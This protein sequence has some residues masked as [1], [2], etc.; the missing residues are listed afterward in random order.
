MSTIA[1]ISKK[2]DSDTII[3]SI[4]ILIIVFFLVVFFAISFR[5]FVGQT[6]NSQCPAQNCATNIIS[7]VRRCP[8]S[9]T[10]VTFDSQ[11]EVCND[12]QGCT[13]PETRC[14][15]T[16]PARGTSCPGDP[17]YSGLCNASTSGAGSTGSTDCK[18]LSRMY[19]P[20]FATVYFKQVIVPDSGTISPGSGNSSAGTTGD[21]GFTAFVQQT[22]WTDSTNRPR[23]DLPLSMGIFGSDTNTTCSIS[24]S[25]LP[26]AFPLTGCIVGRYAIDSTSGNVF[27][28]NVPS[29]LTCP[30]SLPK[31]LPTGTFVCS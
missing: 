11:E 17:N 9:T 10:A 26:R 16:D 27:C 31:R 2:Y 29:T 14:V 12:V 25:N 19:C 15:Y 21:P 18:C 20:D 7:G 5:D 28:M 1:K 13:N 30:S 3:P 6:Q 4:A 8:T 24:E 23:S 22:V